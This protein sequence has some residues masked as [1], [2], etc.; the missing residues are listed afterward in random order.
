MTVK[1]IP[2]GYQTVT[3]Y[4]M[5]R[6]AAKFIE[7]MSLVFDA[8]TAEQLMR[9]DGTIGHS[10]LRIGNSMI[11]LSEASESYPATPVMLHVYVENVDTVFE[12][13]VRAGG[14]VVSK[15]TDQFYGDRA[16]GVREPSGNTVWI[17]THIE[18]VAPDELKRRALAAMQGGN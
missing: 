16:G 4:L 17:A 1:T 5:V 7:F 3:P 6:D 12:R 11:M 9:P 15:P 2:D 8:T 18:D 14:T 13:A 10:E